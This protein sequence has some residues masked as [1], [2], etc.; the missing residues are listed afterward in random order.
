MSTSLTCSPLSALPPQPSSPQP[1]SGSVSALEELSSTPDATSIQELYRLCVS[2]LC[3]CLTAGCCE[4]ADSKVG[5][6][7]LCRTCAT[8]KMYSWVRSSKDVVYEQPDL[9]FMLKMFHLRVSKVSVICSVGALKYFELTFRDGK[10]RILILQQCAAEM[11][12]YSD[13]NHQHA[14]FADELQLTVVRLQLIQGHTLPLEHQPLMYPVRCLSGTVY[15]GLMLSAHIQVELSAYTAG[16]AQIGSYIVGDIADMLQYYHSRDYTLENLMPELIVRF[17]QPGS[18]RGVL[19]VVNLSC[20]TT[21]D[22]TESA[23]H[24][25]IPALTIARGGGLYKSILAQKAMHDFGIPSLDWEA[26]VYALF[27][28]WARAE[29]S[30]SASQDKKP[31]KLA[32]SA[33]TFHADSDILEGRVIGISADDAIS[34]HISRIISLKKKILAK[35]GSEYASVSAA[36]ELSRVA[37]F[38]AAMLKI[39]E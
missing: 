35:L 20:G 24:V 14:S 29:I 31:S 6:S 10:R 19:R 21:C 7:L 27:T 17:P 18:E 32:Q 26:A 23:A 38:K 34:K 37:L 8:R 28:I 9:V 33:H 2:S 15:R 30:S 5:N 25:K 3:K 11:G 13:G 1:L 36:S 22:Y 12:E 39:F 16:D 4:D